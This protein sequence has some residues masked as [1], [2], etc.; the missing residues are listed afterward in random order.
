MWRI[1]LKRAFQK[2]DILSIFVPI[3]IKIQMS[4]SWKANWMSRPRA[5]CNLH[6]RPSVILTYLTW[7]T[8]YCLTNTLNK[9]TV[10]NYHIETWLLGQNPNFMMHLY[11]QAKA[12]KAQLQKLEKKSYLPSPSAKVTCLC[13]Y[14]WVV[15]EQALQ[16]ILHLTLAGSG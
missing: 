1:L 7:L 14:G 15:E 11:K 4:F 13:N 2:K 10:P 3:D 12:L 9:S 6:F 5:L 8:W 16:L